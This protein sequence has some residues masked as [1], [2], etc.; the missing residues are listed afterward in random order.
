MNNIE[1]EQ[2]KKRLTDI[3]L[4]YNIYMDGIGPQGDHNHMADSLTLEVQKIVREEAERIFTQFCIA[5]SGLTMYQTEQAIHW[6]AQELHKDMMQICGIE[7]KQAN[8]EHTW[9][10]VG[11]GYD[12]QLAKAVTWIFSCEKCKATKEEPIIKGESS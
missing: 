2:I 10:L 11:S 12:L 3:L 4:R 1:L 7:D 5:T 9:R 6:T 8:C